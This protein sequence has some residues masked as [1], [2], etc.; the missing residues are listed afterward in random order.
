MTIGQLSRACG[1]T[2][3][4][5]RYY[6]EAGL[7]A[8]ARRRANGYR[9][10][11][12]RDVDTLRFVRRARRLGFPLEDISALLALWSDRRR[13]SADVRALALNHLAE[14]DRRI[15]EM[16]T[17]RKALHHLIERCHGDDR[18]DCPILD[19]LAGEDDD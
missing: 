9:D 7:I 2:A 10:Y 8:S 6:E 16:K 19:Q 15:A 14:I 1:V 5:I 12:P 18:P 13:A 17:M 4:T 3:K 11:G